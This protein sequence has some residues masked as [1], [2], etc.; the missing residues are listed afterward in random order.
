[1]N[2]FESVF[3]F[4]VLLLIQG[5]GGSGSAGSAQSSNS[6]S[7]NTL[8]SY[9]FYSP[10]GVESNISIIGY[11]ALKPVKLG[12]YGLGDVPLY[13][14]GGEAGL[15]KNH[16]GVKRECSE[17]IPLHTQCFF[18]DPRD[19]D[20][21]YDRDHVCGFLARPTMVV[22]CDDVQCLGEAYYDDCSSG[23][24]TTSEPPTFPE[25]VVA[26]NKVMT[27]IYEMSEIQTN[28][29]G[30]NVYYTLSLDVASVMVES[31]RAPMVNLSKIIADFKGNIYPDAARRLNEAVVKYPAIF[32]NPEA[33]FLIIDEPFWTGS[34][35][36]DEAKTKEHVA[37][38][39]QTALMIRNNNPKAKIGINL[40]PNY[41]SYDELSVDV[42]SVANDVDWVGMDVYVF[43]GKSNVNASKQI[44]VFFD[45][46]KSAYPDKGNMIVLQVFSPID[47]K[48]PGEWTKNESNEFISLMSP[49]LDFGY[50]FDSV[51]IWGGGSVSELPHEYAGFNLPPDVVDFYKNK[52]IDISR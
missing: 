13:R 28:P 8:K 27:S 42:A 26:S 47:W 23:P 49:L 45:F 51:M 9:A 52:I 10:Y 46:M 33:R 18:T 16:G 4:F 35:H 44:Q 37:L 12:F 6:S 38:I 48:K 7:E 31:G 5:C 24:R 2:R 34:G 3:V 40:A 32:L 50:K 36:T 22:A 21:R 43:F 11:D 29:L 41:K 39:H 15:W 25:S 30:T 17:L 19:M 1:M 20:E 14:Y